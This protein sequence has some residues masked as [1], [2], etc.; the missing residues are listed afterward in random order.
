MPC[1]CPE[2]KDALGK[3][4]KSM[5]DKSGKL[6]QLLRDLNQNYGTD[7]AAKLRL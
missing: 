1:N 3:C 2:T 7:A 5:I 6:R 4:M